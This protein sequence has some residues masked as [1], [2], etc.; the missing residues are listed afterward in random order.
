[1]VGLVDRVTF[2]AFR[3]R[4]LFEVSNVSSRVFFLVRETYD[5]RAITPTRGMVE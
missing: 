4:N 1:M 5:L 2:P 3:P